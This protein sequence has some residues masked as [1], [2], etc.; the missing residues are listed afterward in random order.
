MFSDIFK[1]F[2]CAGAIANVHLTIST[3]LGYSKWS[4]HEIALFLSILV[5]YQVYFAIR[6]WRTF[7]K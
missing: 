3:M 5:F 4:D 1:F 2:M 6:E 7:D